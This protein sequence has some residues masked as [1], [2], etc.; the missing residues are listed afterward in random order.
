MADIEDRVTTLER[1]VALLKAR[2]GTNEEDL[3]S[4]PDLIRTEFRLTNSQISRLTN[5]VAQLRDLP[6]KFNELEAKF[7]TLPRIIAEM[8]AERDKSR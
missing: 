8:L 4:I 2:V 3:K 5:D 1:E 6:R 7:D